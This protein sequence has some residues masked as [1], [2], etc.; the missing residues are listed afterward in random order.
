MG[1]LWLVGSLKW[2]VSSAEYRLFYRSLLQKR[3]II[4]RSLLIVDTPDQTYLQG[5]QIGMRIVNTS[6][7]TYMRHETCKR[8][9]LSLC[10][11]HT[12]THTHTHTHIHLRTHTYAHTHKHK[13][14]HTF[15]L[16]LSLSQTH[17]H[18]HTQT[19]TRTHSLSLSLSLSYTH[20]HT[21]THTHMHMHM[22][23]HTHTY[24]YTPT[25]SHTHCLV[26]SAGR[27]RSGGVHEWKRRM[28]TEW[29]L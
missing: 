14:A 13:H 18:T 3:P 29:D 9:L 6:K 16:S 24:A 5:D 22:H 12:H 21:H 27:P 15:S 11:N 4:L 10:D 19:Q 1:W 23:T 8:D 26:L 2:W 17:T 25:Q 20:T 28:H 7:E